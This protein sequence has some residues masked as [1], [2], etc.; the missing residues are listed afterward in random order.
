M[1]RRLM[2][3]H[4]G[5]GAGARACRGGDLTVRSC[6][7]HNATRVRACIQLFSAHTGIE[8]YNAEKPTAPIPFY[9]RSPLGEAHV[10]HP[11]WK[12]FRITETPWLE[13][14]GNRRERR[15]LTN[16]VLKYRPKVVPG[17]PT[18][19]DDLEAYAQFALCRGKMLEYA[20]CSHG[21]FSHPIK[22]YLVSVKSPARWLYSVMRNCPD[23]PQ[24]AADDDNGL[25]A[26]M[27]RGKRVGGVHG[28]N[29]AQQRPAR[30][31]QLWNNFYGRWLD[32]ARSNP[33]RVA[34]VR[35]EDIIANCR[36]AIETAARKVGVKFTPTDGLPATHKGQGCHGDAGPS[37]AIFMS[38]GR[39]FKRESEKVST[40][41]WAGA[42]ARQSERASTCLTQVHR[43][44]PPPRPWS[45]APHA[46]VRT[47]PLLVVPWLELDERDGQARCGRARQARRSRAD[48]RAWLQLY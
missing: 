30:Y 31:V 24:Y 34:I 25:G 26:A 10:N 16:D 47:R 21:K 38:G 35:Y 40:R 5:G 42:R 8:M 13:A 36:G 19:L 41:A 29:P 7:E 4:P 44:F 20:L 45:R 48:G 9:W 37:G 33:G 2:C 23:C 12:H 46:H 27:F 32:L 17:G 6:S 14:G 1:T 11:G 43:P 39:D 28:R 15:N 3:A 22:F 18:N